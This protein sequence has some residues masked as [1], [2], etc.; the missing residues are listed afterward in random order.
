ME[1]AGTTG[2]SKLTRTL[3]EAFQLPRMFCFESGFVYEALRRGVSG[4]ALIAGVSVLSFNGPHPAEEAYNLFFF[5]D[6]PDP[7]FR[8]PAERIS[9]SSLVGGIRS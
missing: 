3:Q 9:L 2:R 7:Q 4:T 6:V 5:S 8:R 1:A